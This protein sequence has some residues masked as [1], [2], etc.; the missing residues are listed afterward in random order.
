MKKEPTYEEAFKEL[1]AIVRE[2][3]SGELSV[4]LIFTRI[5]RASELIRF[6]KGKLLL[7]EKNIDQTLKDMDNQLPANS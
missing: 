3:E 5:K 1:N 6:C 7:T 4:D 2:I